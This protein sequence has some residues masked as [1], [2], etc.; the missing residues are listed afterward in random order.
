[1]VNNDGKYKILV[2]K[3]KYHG[4]RE[5]FKNELNK[6]IKDN[7]APDAM[8]TLSK[9]PSPPEVAPVSSDGF[10]RGEHSY[11]NISINT[12]LSVGAALSDTSPPSYIFQD[13]SKRN[14]SNESTIG[15]SQTTRRTWADTVTGQNTPAPESLVTGQAGIDQSTIISDLESSRAEVETL[16]SKVAQLEA[17]RAEQ[18]KVL[19]DTVQEQVT[20][21]VQ[22]QM[23]QMF[24]KLVTTLHQA[25]NTISKRSA[26]EMEEENIMEQPT[27]DPDNAT[28]KRC[29][30]K[31]T[32]IKNST[33]K[34][35]NK[36]QERWHTPDY[37]EQIATQ[38]DW[39]E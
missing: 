33:I 20:K 16:K 28:H 4:T 29:D 21:A 39:S 17:E 10:S 36:A 6:W 31:E 22:D 3:D 27:E 23:S 30:N 14:A 11:M 19:A 18:Q 1:M 13:T 38:S 12:A 5:R 2:E 26:Q 15:V 32:P 25:P 8:A 9:F 7:A 35:I 24:A 34:G 37:L